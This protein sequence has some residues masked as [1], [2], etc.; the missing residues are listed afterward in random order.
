MARG[1]PRLFGLRAF[2]GL[3]N[4]GGQSM[5]TDNCTGSFSFVSLRHSSLFLCS[6]GVVARGLGDW[7]ALV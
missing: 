6:G 7:V 2:K 3:G 1:R 4:A 5:R